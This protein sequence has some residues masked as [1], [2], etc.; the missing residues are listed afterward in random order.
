MLAEQACCLL[1]S[2]GRDGDVAGR[3]LGPEVVIQTP[4]V[5]VLPGGLGVS[6]KS[7]YRL[8]TEPT[9]SW[10]HFGPHKRAHLSSYRSSRAD[11]LTTQA[12]TASAP[13][14]HGLEAYHIY[15]MR[16]YTRATSNIGEG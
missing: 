8:R 15:P 13:S 11:E 16:Y 5:G 14:T 1:D 10:A 4:L 12:A 6:S 3:L 9:V 7:Q 2:R